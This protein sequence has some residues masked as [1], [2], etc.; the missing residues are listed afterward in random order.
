MND[1]LKKPECPFCY[2]SCNVPNCSVVGCD[3]S[4]EICNKALYCGVYPHQV[5]CKQGNCK[6]HI[7]AYLDKCIERS[8][9]RMFEAAVL[10]VKKEG[11]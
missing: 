6:K 2:V 7:K 3:G 4:K 1:E 9:K 5:F 11:F 8:A 10:N